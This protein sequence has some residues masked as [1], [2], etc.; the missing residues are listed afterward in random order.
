[1]TLSCS[2]LYNCYLTNETDKLPLS[3]PA[4]NEHILIK[5]FGFVVRELLKN[6]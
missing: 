2:V 3:P 4:M 1:M 5:P 6:Q